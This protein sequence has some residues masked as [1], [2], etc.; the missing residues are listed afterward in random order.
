MAH[1]DISFN[2]ESAHQVTARTH[3]GRQ[4]FSSNEA[5]VPVSQNVFNF[6]FIESLKPFLLIRAVVLKETNLATA[7]RRHTATDSES[8]H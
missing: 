2:V 4:R 6:L 5:L 8:P 7:Q 3:A 1:P